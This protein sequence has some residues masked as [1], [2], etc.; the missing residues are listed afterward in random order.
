MA[1][2]AEIFQITLAGAPLGLGE[3]HDIELALRLLQ[4]TGGEIVLDLFILH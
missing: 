1:S 4:T 3:L 2:M